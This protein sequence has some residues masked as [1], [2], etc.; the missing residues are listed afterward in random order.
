M[1]RLLNEIHVVIP[2]IPVQWI[3]KIE[4]Y[5]PDLPQFPIMYIHF[6]SADKRIIACPVS[7]SYQIT[8]AKCSAD[9]F[10]LCNTQPTEVVKNDLINEISN[11][12]GL[13][14]SVN[15]ETVKAC[16]KGNTEY[17]KLF[18]KLWE[19]IKAS[20]GE[21]IPYG[22]F[23]EKLYSIPRF[24]AAW[25][26]K[27]GR[28]SEMRM[29]YNFMKFFGEEVEFPESWSHLEFY[30]IPTYSEIDINTFESFQKFGKLYA[31]IT[32]LFD[33]EF[34]EESSVEPYSFHSLPKAWDKKRD[35]FT[36]NVLREHKK[37]G[38]LNDEE[39]EYIEKLVDAFNR[40]PWRAAYFIS[41]IKT[42]EIANYDKWN[43]SFI[44]SFYDNCENMIGYSGKVVACFLQQGFGNDEAIP[45][46]TWIE[47]FYKFVLGIDNRS[48]F[49]RS[50]D[51]L[52]KLER[53]I[54]LA[55]QSNK[56]NMKGFYNTL[57]CQRYGVNNNKE[58]RGVNPLACCQCKLKERCIGL[59]KMSDEK[60]YL[61]GKKPVDGEGEKDVCF[62]CELEAKVPKKIH[63][64]KNGKR[65][66][67]KW[68]PTDEF[69]GYTINY[70]NCLTDDLISEKTVTFKRLL[71]A[72]NTIKVSDK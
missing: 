24:V 57:W 37:S 11:R 51:H 14:D 13:A 20:Y 62:F 19:F 21:S 4:L 43:K 22:R 18:E 17:E 12:I 9:F 29:L 40:H 32:K 15:I 16:C 66:I 41:A 68:I 35:D 46:D 70:E 25:Q 58:L 42:I 63:K 33:L 34:T 61:S 65:K 49:Y 48:D 52:G 44:C 67:G 45:V 54:W 2:D 47:T 36:N 1:F 30:V 28:Q 59:S 27:T 55:S 69:S 64:R 23:Y 56:T 10:V 50:F 60:I 31:A 26:P 7:V 6:F 71:D 38:E 39:C 53:V 5:Y 72:L 8:G 3:P